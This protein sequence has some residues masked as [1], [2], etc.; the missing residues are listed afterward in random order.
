MAL[1]LSFLLFPPILCASRGEKNSFPL[2]GLH[3]CMQ[4]LEEEHVAYIR[5]FPV[6]LSHQ[7]RA[8]PFDCS[9]DLSS[10]SIIV[11]CCFV[12]SCSV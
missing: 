8:L 3:Y 7:P 10:M 2:R 6:P 12:F 9:K 11:F 1:S 5:P 4:K